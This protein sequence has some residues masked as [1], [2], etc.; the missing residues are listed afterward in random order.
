MAFNRMRR[1]RRRWDIIVL[2][3]L[4]AGAATFGYEAFYKHG[5]RYVFA[6]LGI[7]APVPTLTHQQNV[8]L[9]ALEWCESSGI[10]TAVNPKDLDG[11]PSYYSFQFKP[12]TFKQYGVKYGMLSKSITDAEV[13]QLLGDYELQKEMVT[14]MMFDERVRWHREFPAC[15]RNLGVPPKATSTQTS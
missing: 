11:T 4:I 6:S 10:K 5:L 3:I 15:V 8:W 14:R 2:I 1:L 12:S 9:H 7:K 13:E